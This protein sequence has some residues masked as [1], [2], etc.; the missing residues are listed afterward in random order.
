[1]TGERFQV[2]VRI[3]VQRI[4]QHGSTQYGEHF[5]INETGVVH[6][7]DFGAVAKVMQRFH[8]LLAELR[9]PA[10]EPEKRR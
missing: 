6:A 4:D 8:D 5:S 1:M 3:E 7:T 2:N 9:G 10:L